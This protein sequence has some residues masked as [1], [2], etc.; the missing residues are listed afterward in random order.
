MIWQKMT[1]EIKL[2]E[3]KVDNEFSQGK[4]NIP[5]IKTIRVKVCEHVFVEQF[6]KESRQ[7]ITTNKIIIIGTLFGY[8]C[9]R[10]FIVLCS[11]AHT[12]TY[13][14]IYIH[15]ANSPQWEKHKTTGNARSLRREL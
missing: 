13:K 7:R 15:G 2:A 4:T 9:L 8:Y 5:I 6:R 10:I 3:S 1:T 11:H 14:Y 12:P